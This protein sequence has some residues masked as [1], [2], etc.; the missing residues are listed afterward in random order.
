[1]GGPVSAL[2]AGIHD[3]YEDSTPVVEFGEKTVSRG[4]FAA[5]VRRVAEQLSDSGL[6]QGDV[7]AVRD[8]DDWQWIAVMLG[9]WR[10]GGIFLPQTTP[11]P[12]QHA[13]WPRLT[14]HCSAPGGPAVAGRAEADATRLTDGTAYLLPTSGSTGRSKWIQGTLHGL[15]HFVAWEIEELRAGPDDI[16]AQL[17]APTFDPVLREV[18]VPL[19]AGARLAVPEDRAGLVR[20]PA[21]LDWL[22]R[23]GVTLVHAVPTLARLWCSGNS[24]TGLPS[25]RALL[26]AGEP[27]YEGDL[28]AWA[29]RFGTGATL[30][31]L[32]G[33]SET[34]LAKCAQRIDLTLIKEA[35]SEG[36]AVVGPPLPECGI[37][38]AD[39]D[40][41]C[42]PYEVGEVL[43]RTPHA[44]NGYWDM[45][46]LNEA[47]FV[48]NPFA[49]E[50]PVRVFRTRDL[51]YQLP[52]GR[53]V[54][55]GR[56]DA[57]YKFRGVRV[58]LGLIEDAIRRVPG[59]RDAGVNVA[60]PPTGP[61]V[62]AA[63]VVTDR[64][65]QDIAHELPTDLQGPRPGAWR[66]VSELPRTHSGKLERNA[67]PALTAGEATTDDTA[68]QDPSVRTL[69][70]IWRE[71]MPLAP[72]LGAHSS[73]TDAGGQSIEAVQALNRI[74]DEFGAALGLRDLLDLQ[75]PY[76]IAARIAAVQG[77][78]RPSRTRL[79]SLP[80]T[81]PQ[82]LTGAQERFW[83]W[84]GRDEEPVRFQFLWAARLSGP[85][86][87][88][89]LAEAADTVLRGAD[90]QWLA[91]SGSGTRVR[92]SSFGPHPAVEVVRP[93]EGADPHSW[94]R[95]DAER[96]AVRPFA[97]GTEPLMR[98][99]IYPLGPDETALVLVNH[100]LAS[101]GWTKER[102]LRQV[103][104]VYAG[105]EPVEA[106][107]FS[108]YAAWEAE[109]RPLWPDRSGYWDERLRRLTGM[110]LPWRSG[111]GNNRQNHALR[112]VSWS[113]DREESQALR[114]ACA[115]AGT[116]LPSAVA[117]ALIR[118]LQE[119]TGRPDGQ[120]LLSN[121]KRPDPRLNSTLGCFTDS[122]VL[123]YGALPEAPAAAARTVGDEIGTALRQ[124]QPSFLWL[125]RRYRP[126]LDPH[127]PRTFPV[128]FAPQSDYSTAVNLPG[129]RAQALDWGERRWMWP[130]EFYPVVTG[131]EIHFHLHHATEYFDH[132]RVGELAAALRAEL[133]RLA[134]NPAPEHPPAH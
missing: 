57:E 31:N 91:F 17:T 134:K 71:V 11:D 126:D 7:V 40:R 99:R 46:D 13:P 80:A 127:D 123:P 117:A 111:A 76:R 42:A 54:V 110:R 128:I 28:Y 23:T 8:C 38:V 19:V 50:D 84:I 106:L 15:D 109:Q 4:E 75:T 121:A 77:G 90:G 70:G 102:Y 83:E 108:A 3:W 56:L 1:M 60:T 48:R 112:T 129:V 122:T 96:T 27:L 79:G 133:A 103:C 132:D 43:I 100:V 59:V 6:R 2:V 107:R 45:P 47:R 82:P 22:A 81:G 113:L 125:L 66:A 55:E 20:S 98:V 72:G 101:D 64:P 24:R 68:D 51:G 65:V 5:L 89:R 67:L 29:D 10:S 44:S 62:I 86:D 34:T 78:P 25:L 115:A 119:W 93:P 114:T 97:F 58:D 26:L 63:Y 88:A 104:A 49:P 41:R 37:L 116:T 105:E 118:G 130:L 94:C 16:C 30:Y 124:S 73:F 35:V 52:D 69:L 39:G 14:V 12:A 131:P 36:K 92:Q 61:A 74:E 21:A 87:T 95:T 9:I 33:P 85:V 120:L 18:L 53:L 32:Y